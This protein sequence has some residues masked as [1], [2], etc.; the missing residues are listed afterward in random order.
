MYACMSEREFTVH[1]QTPGSDRQCF[2]G[3]AMCAWALSH[4][5]ACISYCRTLACA[6]VCSCI[7][8]S[9]LCNCIDKSEYLLLSHFNNNYWLRLFIVFGVRLSVFY[10]IFYSSG[11]D[12]W[13]GRNSQR[14]AAAATA[15]AIHIVWLKILFAVVLRLSRQRFSR[16]HWLSLIS[17]YLL[18][19]LLQLFLL[20]IR[21]FLPVVNTQSARGLSLLHVDIIVCGLVIRFICYRLLFVSATLI[22]LIVNFT[23]VWGIVC[24]SFVSDVCSTPY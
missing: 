24:Q 1:T 14:T 13:L 21:A 9:F 16:Y 6:P 4:Y 7:V 23:R 18:C 11:I 5:Y 22:W 3:N 2:G 8:T 12:Y 19:L 20:D 15:A 10:M 17:L